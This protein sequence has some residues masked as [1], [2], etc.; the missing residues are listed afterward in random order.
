VYNSYAP[1]VVLKPVDWD[2]AFIVLVKSTLLMLNVA[3]GL[4][5]EPESVSRI[6]SEIMAEVIVSVIGML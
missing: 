6:P 1:V 2:S 3:N 5:I 4:V